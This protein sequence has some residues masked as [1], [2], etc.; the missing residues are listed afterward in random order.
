MKAHLL[1]LACL[2]N[3]LAYAKPFPPA[4]SL[5]ELV[6]A[7]VKDR[8]HKSPH[9]AEGPTTSSAPSFM[10]I[11]RP[12]ELPVLNRLAAI[13]ATTLPAHPLSLTPAEAVELSSALR[14]VAPHPAA[15]V[16]V[17]GSLRTLAP[18][19]FRPPSELIAET[20]SLNLPG[21]APM[22]V[23]SFRLKLEFMWDKPHGQWMNQLLKDIN[24]AK[25]AGDLETYN[26]LTARYSAWA[27]KYL[28][29]A[30]PPKLDGLR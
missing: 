2:L 21:V 5:N 8:K 19:I 9:Y 10:Q 12:T 14:V 7:A 25:A 13:P 20:A 27:E 15:H 26:A 30:E 16:P 23:D 24:A 6:A 4:P 28:R 11:V 3:S 29:R 17:T 18:L 22:T 1:L